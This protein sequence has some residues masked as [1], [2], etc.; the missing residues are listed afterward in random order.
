MIRFIKLLFY[1]IYWYYYKVDKESRIS[2]KLATWLVF[3]LL[4]GIILY[5]AFEL[6]YISFDKTIIFDTPYWQYAF[7][8]FIVG[9]FVGIYIYNEDFKKFDSFRDYHIKY[10]LYFFIIAGFAL[11]LAFYSGSI[12]RERI[13]KQRE[14]HKTFVEMKK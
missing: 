1:H 12:N 7:L 6:I 4:F 10:Y 8:Y 3:T 5:F 9:F 14:M 2:A 13:F 11:S